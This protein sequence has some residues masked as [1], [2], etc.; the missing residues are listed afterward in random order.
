MIQ[1]IL[2][3]Y[4]LALHLAV[5]FFVS[6]VSVLYSNIW[7]SVSLFWLSLF[8]IQSFLLLPSML[9]GE[10]LGEARLRAGENALHDPFVYTGVALVV[11]ACLQWLNSGCS[12]T[13]LDDAEIWRYSAPPVG[14]LPFSIEPFPAL[15]VL[16]LFAVCIAGGWILRNGAGKASKRFFLNAASMLSG[17]IALY[18]VVMSLAG[19]PPYP[20]WAA[21]PGACNW[22][23]C[24]GFWMLVALGGHLNFVEDRFSKTFAWSAFSLLGN[25]LGML[26]FGEPLGNALFVVA[27][28]GLLGYWVFF[29]ARQPAGG[30]GQ[31]KLFGCVF[32]AF[33]AVL[34][35]SYLFPENPAKGKFARLADTHYYETLFDGRQFQSPLAWKIWQDNPWTGAGTGGFTHYSRT[36]VE[37]AD[38]ARLGGCGGLLSNDW[39]QFL[40]E[41]GIIGSG[42]LAGLLIVLIIPLFSRLR[43]AYL[44]AGSGNGEGAGI[45]PYVFS[46][47]AAVALVFGLSFFFSPLQSGVMLISFMYVL[48]VIPGFLPASVGQT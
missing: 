47:G 18:M 5:L 14:W 31:L 43:A 4:W 38:W 44:Q 12:L 22:G 48:A 1:K 20:A 41:Y 37:E 32:V 21:S 40:T 30:I 27:A 25:L 19:R 24:F 45:D 13:Y 33:G 8:A 29:L 36:L 2:T 16:A 9:R 34:V 26:Q 10:S 7:M 28:L 15:A 23:V 17:G 3:K 46:G 42:L 11:F 6:W 35:S 39:L